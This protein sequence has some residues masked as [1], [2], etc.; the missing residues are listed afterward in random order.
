MTTTSIN[1]EQVDL[2]L[3]EIVQ[4]V[5]S[6]SR[7]NKAEGLLFYTKAPLT[8]LGSLANSIREQKNGNKVFFN[9]NIHI[10]PTNICVFDCKF[11][12]YSIKVSKKEDAWELSIDEMVDKLKAYENKDITEV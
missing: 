12:A 2:E 6:N 10:E 1:I 7:I 9:K 4:K 11:C 3:Q 5:I 8:L